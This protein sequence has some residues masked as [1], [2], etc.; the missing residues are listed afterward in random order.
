MVTLRRSLQS[1]AATCRRGSHRRLPAH[2]KLGHLILHAPE[3]F[4]AVW[5]REVVQAPA[6]SSLTPL[7]LRWSA[8][9]ALNLST[10]DRRCRLR[11]WTGAR[12]GLWSSPRSE[13][14][15]NKVGWSGV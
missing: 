3:V 10:F 8:K 1:L 4:I 7:L 11:E 6:P 12:P 15:C 5:C 14:A 2:G 9:N 13:G